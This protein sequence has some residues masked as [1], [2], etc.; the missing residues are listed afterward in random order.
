MGQ[1]TLSLSL[2]WLGLATRR[3]KIL[4]VLQVKKTDIEQLN[5]TVGGK[6]RAFCRSTSSQGLKLISLI[7]IKDVCD[8]GVQSFLVRR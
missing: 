8:D 1:M 2:T 4:S 7:C 6:S 5:C 3:I